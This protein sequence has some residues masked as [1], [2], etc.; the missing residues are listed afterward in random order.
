MYSVVDCRQMRPYNRVH[1]AFQ[2]D[3]KNGENPVVDWDIL[4]AVV[5]IPILKFHRS[6]HLFHQEIQPEDVM[7]A[8]PKY[9]GLAEKAIKRQ[10]KNED[11]KKTSWQSKQKIAKIA[12]REQKR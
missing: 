12:K 2:L 8:L 4:I 1:H 6:E 7:I 11:K 3:P 9:L 10:V 5:S